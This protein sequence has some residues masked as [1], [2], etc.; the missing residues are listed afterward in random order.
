MI[1]YLFIFLFSV[2]KYNDLLFYMNF[3]DYCIDL[4]YNNLANKARN[5]S[6]VDDLL[7]F[8]EYAEVAE[9]QTR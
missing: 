5:S 3:I 4:V 7:F 2:I 9:W 6:Q 8:N 1:R